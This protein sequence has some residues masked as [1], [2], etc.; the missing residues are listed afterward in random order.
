MS[1]SG[2]KS[3]LEFRVYLFLFKSRLD[4]LSI[5]SVIM[6]LT[7]DFDCATSVTPLDRTSDGKEGVK[8]MSYYF[9]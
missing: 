7:S 5:F 4:Y 6:M 1:N 9:F 8:G 3:S 2:Y